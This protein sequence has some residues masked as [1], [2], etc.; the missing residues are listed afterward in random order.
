M[1][2]R[3]ETLEEWEA[4]SQTSFSSSDFIYSSLCLH[5]TAIPIPSLILQNPAPS[6]INQ[7]KPWK[8]ERGAK[9]NIQLDFLPGIIYFLTILMKIK[10]SSLLK[11]K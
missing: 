4:S 11:Y 3:N 7:L 5:F 1:Q 8:G 9:E 2:L 6:Y 10:Q